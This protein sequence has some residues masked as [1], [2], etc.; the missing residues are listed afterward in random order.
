MKRI[1]NKWQQWWIARL[2]LILI[3]FFLFIKISYAEQDITIL[4]SSDRGVTIAFLPTVERLDT[5]QLNGEIYYKIYLSHT[6]FVGNPGEPMIPVRV[7]NV[8]IPLESEVNVSILSV[9]SREMRGKLLPAPEIDPTGRYN[10]EI[11]SAIYQSSEFFPQQIL[12]TDPPGFIR[13]QRIVKIKL[14]AA[15]FLGQLERI[16]I[17]NKI[18]VRVDFIGKIDGSIDVKNSAGDDEFYRGV[19]VNYSQSKRWLK[20]HARQLKRVKTIFQN[21]NWYKMS[22]RQEG[23]YKIT[24]EYLSSQ[25]IDIGSIKTESIRIYN[26]GGREL[27]QNLNTTRPD[28][29]VENAIRIVDMNSNGKFDNVDY[30]LFYGKAVNNWAPLNNSNEFYQHYI[31]HYTYDNIYWLTWNDNAN[32]KRMENKTV[33]SPAGI[34]PVPYFRGLHFNEDEINN[35]L[36]SGLNWFGR[37]MVGQNVQQGYSVYLPNPANQ[38]NR[39]ITILRSI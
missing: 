25:G 2:V 22:I 11:K 7:V 15:Q 6:S 28:S 32:G 39:D 31:N 26:N 1:K 12:G 3:A 8:G 23:I 5:V 18:I 16:K 20:T 29:L 35:Y 34:D 33:P 19:V 14:F 36:N 37:L 9:E 17:H 38:D 4:D 30:I 24:R 21:E 10:F 13:D 27:P